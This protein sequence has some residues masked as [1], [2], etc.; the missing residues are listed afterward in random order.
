M[1]SQ[2]LPNPQLRHV[3]SLSMRSNHGH[4]DSE[5]VVVVLSSH[6]IC[7]SNFYVG[8]RLARHFFTVFCH[9]TKYCTV[10]KSRW[11]SSLTVFSGGSASQVRCDAVRLE[12]QL[13]TIPVFF[14]LD[15]IETLDLTVDVWIFAP[16]ICLE[17]G[18]WRHRFDTILKRF[19]ALRLF[20]FAP[21]A[22]PPRHQSREA[23]RHLLG[24]SRQYN[25]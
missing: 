9:S 5:E 4:S 21:G 12:Q 10:R 8:A 24:A 13:S 20:V 25:G 16:I 22:A 17:Q 19:E 14:P 3:M 18:S 15:N 6:D 7:L 23:L 2:S 11:M 1:S